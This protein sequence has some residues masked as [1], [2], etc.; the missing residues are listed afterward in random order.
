[1]RILGA[2][3]K[4]CHQAR[5]KFTMAQ[6]DQPNHPKASSEIQ[7]GPDDRILRG[8]SSCTL[9]FG[10]FVPVQQESLT[11]TSLAPRHGSQ[12]PPACPKVHHRLCRHHAWVLP[13]IVA[14]RRMLVLNL[15]VCSS[16][17]RDLHHPGVLPTRN[18]P[19]IPRYLTTRSL[20]CCLHICS[21]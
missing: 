5:Q 16:S 18:A 10:T 21:F 19:S 3:E 4:V 13:A 15:G 12:S 20:S 14:L 6:T 9:M 8:C 11:C 17:R 2:P 1:L 7:S